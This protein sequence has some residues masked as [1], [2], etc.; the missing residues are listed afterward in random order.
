[1]AYKVFPDSAA[2]KGEKDKN[3]KASIE[4]VAMAHLMRGVHW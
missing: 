4:Q 1:M 2:A 3:E